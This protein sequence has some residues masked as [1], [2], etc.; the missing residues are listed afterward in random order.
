MAV[1][2]DCLQPKGAREL[3]DTEGQSID[4]LLEPVWSCMNQSCLSALCESPTCLVSHPAKG[5]PLH[6]SRRWTQLPA[7][8]RGGTKP[9]PAQRP[10]PAA[11]P[12]VGKHQST[13]LLSAQARAV[14]GWWGT[15]GQKNPSKLLL[16][17]VCQLFA[18]QE[19]RA[20]AAANS[21]VSARAPQ[22]W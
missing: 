16:L 12:G 1:Q 18:V 19:V 11:A 8:V 5:K 21:P 9:A 20:G 10:Q 13:C 4:A 15:P 6:Q 7:G 22:G 2:R 14:C 17:D 3:W